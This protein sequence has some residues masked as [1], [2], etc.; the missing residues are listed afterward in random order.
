MDG[1]I[2]QTA[3]RKPQARR[4][5][6]GERC[7]MPERAKYDLSAPKL[8]QKFRILELRG[9]TRSCHRRHDEPTLGSRPLTDSAH[10]KIHYLEDG[11]FWI[12]KQATLPSAPDKRSGPCVDGSRLS[13]VIARAQH[14]SGQPCVRPHMIVLRSRVFACVIRGELS[15]FRRCLQISHPAG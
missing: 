2:T 9:V 8:L 1:R 7:S 3:S 4:H 12:L 10:F 14:R 5:K 6:P 11:G 15:S 13:R